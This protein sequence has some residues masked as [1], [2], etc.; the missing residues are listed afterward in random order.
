M[1]HVPRG[2]V[3]QGDRDEFT[4]KNTLTDWAMKKAKESGGVAECRIYPGISHFEI[5]VR[6]TPRRPLRHLLL[7]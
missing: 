4:S 6:S 1:L 7:L 5:E 3:P 2:N